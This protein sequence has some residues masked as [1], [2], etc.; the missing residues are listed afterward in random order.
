MLSQRSTWGNLKMCCMNTQNKRWINHKGLDAFTHITYLQQCCDPVSLVFE[1]LLLYFPSLYT[2]DIWKCRPNAVQ[3]WA[4]VFQGSNG[5]LQ[6]ATIPLHEL[7]TGKENGIPKWYL[8][9]IFIVFYWFWLHN[10]HL[11][12]WKRIWVVGVTWLLTSHR[13]AG[14]C[15]LVNIAVIIEH[16]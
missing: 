8:A 6:V 12:G 2:F 16:C 11:V 3:I 7:G 9:F 10:K 5:C 15:W 14:S 13:K 1:N 4:P